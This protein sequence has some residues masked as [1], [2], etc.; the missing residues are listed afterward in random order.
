MNRLPNLK[1]PK[2]ICKK[3]KNTSLKRLKHFDVHLEFGHHLM[4][5][6]NAFIVL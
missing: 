5:G 2:K 4:L 3:L 6:K 1:N